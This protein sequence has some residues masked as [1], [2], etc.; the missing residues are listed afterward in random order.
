M[1]VRSNQCISRVHWNVRVNMRSQL[2]LEHRGHAGLVSSVWRVV[3]LRIITWI[4]VIRVAA[5]E[6]WGAESERRQGAVEIAKAK[7][8]VKWSMEALDVTAKAPVHAAEAAMHAS[9]GAVHAATTVA[10][11]SALRMDGEAE[12]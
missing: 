6:P 4:P 1:D 3:G 5:I 10:P 11:A 12:Q 7:V 9:A 2:N 8:I